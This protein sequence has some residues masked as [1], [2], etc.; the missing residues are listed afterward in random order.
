MNILIIKPT[1]PIKSSSIVQRAK[2]IKQ[3]QQQQPNKTN[4]NCG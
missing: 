4:S 3:Q 2:I 1:L